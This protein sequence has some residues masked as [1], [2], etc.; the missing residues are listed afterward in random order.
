MNADGASVAIRPVSVERIFK[1]ANG[2]EI[3]VIS[4]GVKPG[5]MVISEGQMRLMPGAKVKVL[6]GA[7]QS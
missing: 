5:E 6:S 7:S 4:S 1:P 3:S 2:G